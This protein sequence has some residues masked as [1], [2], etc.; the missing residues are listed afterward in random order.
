MIK[1]LS[2]QLEGFE[3]AIGRVRCFAHVL[4]LVVKSLLHQF[5]V[6]KGKW[7]G[8]A[9]EADGALYDLI[10]ES[11]DNDAGDFEAELEGLG[12]IPSGVD[13]DDTDGWVDEIA[14]MMDEECTEFEEEVR[15]VCMVLTKVSTQCLHDAQA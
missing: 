8:P 2:E 6:P 12:D 7:T 10:D 15:P 5:D 4:N 13:I 9:D 14:T 3:G 1:I 11:S